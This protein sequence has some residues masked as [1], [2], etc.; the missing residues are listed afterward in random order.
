MKKSL[1]VV[2]IILAVL[3][4]VVAC[5]KAPASLEGKYVITA[6]EMDG[7]DMLG[8]F[9]EMAAGKNIED[10]FYMEFSKD[11]KFVGVTGGEKQEGTYKVEGKKLIVIVPDSKDNLEAIIDGNSFSIIDKESKMTFSKK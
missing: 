3:L 7:K 9:K 8:M 1:A 10:L 2:G 4:S 11:G 5:S 6:M